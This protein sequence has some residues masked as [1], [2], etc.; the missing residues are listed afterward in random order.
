MRIK[1]LIGIV[2]IGL[3]GSCKEKNIS[4]KKPIKIGDSSLIVTEK[5]SLYLDNFIEDISPS[6]KKNAGAQA[7]SAMKQIDSADASRKIAESVSANTSLSG[8]TINFAECQVIL[9]SLNA[10][11][12]N[13]TQN[14]RATNSVSYVKDGGDF[15]GNQIQVNQLENLN[16]EQRFF[17]KL[18]VDLNGERY[19]LNDLGKYT[20]AWSTLAMKGNVVASLAASSLQFKNV[21]ATAIKNAL[22]REL[23]KKKKTNKE[24]NDLLKL[25]ANTKSQSDAPC[26][27]IPVSTQWRIQGKKDNRTVKKLI[28]MDVNH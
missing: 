9:S 15:M 11:A 14:E 6:S 1:I 5:D 2:C 26:M 21:D 13:M 24:I 17:V 25:I 4:N 10:H 23:R 12:I 27:L 8:F 20:T 18:A 7:R 16:V 22:D 3:L 28:Q 19:I